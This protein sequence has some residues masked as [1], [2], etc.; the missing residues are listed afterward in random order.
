MH[1]HTIS[2]VSRST[3]GTTFLLSLVA[4]LQTLDNLS[5][6]SKSIFLKA[7]LRQLRNK[8][9]CRLI[10]LFIIYTKHSATAMLCLYRMSAWTFPEHFRQE[11]LDPQCTHDHHSCSFRPDQKPVLRWPA[12]WMERPQLRPKGLLRYERWAAL[13]RR[14]WKKDDPHSCCCS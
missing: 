8:Y 13:K 6:H 1:K 14:H 11:K 5:Q 4:S 7:D 12:L 9:E 10:Q 3:N 2:Y